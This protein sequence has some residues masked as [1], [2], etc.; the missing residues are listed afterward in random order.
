LLAFLAYSR[1]AGNETEESLLQSVSLEWNKKQGLSQF[2]LF[3][4]F[5]FAESPYCYQDFSLCLLA[6][7]IALAHWRKC[8]S[9]GI[10]QQA[11]FQSHA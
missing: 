1:A 6:T 8:D 4:E 7:E 3:F 5:G 10:S 11:P 2:C 9:Q